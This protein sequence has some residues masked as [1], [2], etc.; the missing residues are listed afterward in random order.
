MLAPSPST[1]TPSQT[2]PYPPPA[3]RSWGPDNPKDGMLLPAWI[4]ESGSL[5]GPDDHN[6]APM[7]GAVRARVAGWE[8]SW[9]SGTRPEENSK[10]C[11]Y[12]T[13]DPNKFQQMTLGIDILTRAN[14]NPSLGTPLFNSIEKR[15]CSRPPYN[16]TWG[17]RGSEESP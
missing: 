8:V 3:G 16:Y 5:S 12:V 17:E 14:P 1:L 15:V 2:A 10:Q 6:G 9:A 13:Y 11:V 4:E 7:L